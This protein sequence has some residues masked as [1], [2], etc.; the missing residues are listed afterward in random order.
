[1]NTPFV[2]LNLVSL[3]KMSDTIVISLDKLTAYGRKVFDVRNTIANLQMLMKLMKETDEEVLQSITSSM[4]GGNVSFRLGFSSDAWNTIA[5]DLVKQVRL[6]NAVVQLRILSMNPL[7]IYQA[8][9]TNRDKSFLSQSSVKGRIYM[10]GFSETARAIIYSG[11]NQDFIGEGFE[12]RDDSIEYTDNDFPDGVIMNLDPN[13]LFYGFPLRGVYP[14]MGRLHTLEKAG[15]VVV[16]ATDPQLDYQK[17]CTRWGIPIVDVVLPDELSTLPFFNK[18]V[19]TLPPMLIVKRHPNLFHDAPW[20]SATSNR[21]RGL[22]LG[23]PWAMKMTDGKN[24]M[25]PFAD[26]GF[27]DF[28]FSNGASEEETKTFMFLLPTSR[29]RAGVERSLKGYWENTFGKDT[30]MVLQLWGNNIYS[31]QLGDIVQWIQFRA[32]LRKILSQ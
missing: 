16:N 12:E 1:V 21:I 17:Q 4:Q 10:E 15:M 26:D 7:S 8:L 23:V 11:D 28:F 24:P 9:L 32:M 6:L 5:A 19:S 29:S 22:Q 27:V 13:V 30:P 2:N 31:I 20:A 3:N 18:D 25:R 14:T